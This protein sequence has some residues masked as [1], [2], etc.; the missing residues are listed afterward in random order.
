VASLVK[1]S[2][3]PKVSEN[4]TERKQSDK[5]WNMSEKNCKQ[6]STA[7]GLPIF[8]LINDQIPLPLSSLVLSNSTTI[9]V[10]SFI[11]F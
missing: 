2:D 6:D 4:N 5:G 10:I 1:S 9:I 3:K 11:F 8:C 7:H